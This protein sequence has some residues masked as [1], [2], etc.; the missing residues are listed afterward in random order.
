MDFDTAYKRFKSQFQTI[1]KKM[2]EVTQ[3]AQSDLPEAVQALEAL[4]RTLVES[5]FAK[6]LEK[7]LMPRL[8]KL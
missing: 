3:D 1:S 7:K 6:T 5:S 2:A 4:M 8:W